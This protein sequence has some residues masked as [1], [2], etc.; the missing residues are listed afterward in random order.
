MERIAPIPENVT[1]GHA[2]LARILDRSNQQDSLVRSIAEQVGYAI[3]EGQ[4]QPGDDLNSV[5]LSHQ[6]NTS[7]TPV[8]E[9]LLWLEKE[10]LVEIPPRRRPRVTR[11]GLKE[12][13]DIYEVRANL[14]SLVAELIVAR[15]S[16]ADIVRLEPFKDQMAA[17]CQ[18]GDLEGYFWANVAFQDIETE[19]C[20]NDQV[21][22][23]LDSLMLRMLKLRY[24]SLSH[25]GRL[26]QS[27]QDHE[28]LLRAYIERDAPLAAALKRGIV[29]RGLAVIE[30]S[31]WSGDESP[32]GVSGE[33]LAE[34]DLPEDDR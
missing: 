27:L 11:L 10:G 26:E 15:A 5:D 32:D 20:G 29:R 17:A 34:E 6:F 3:I 24:S 33:I 14:Y 22:R 25:P 19:I 21:R 12:V 23:I 1:G 13:R 16:D 30:R 4:L 28:R 2:V 9:A 31:G 18:A 8:R 7:R